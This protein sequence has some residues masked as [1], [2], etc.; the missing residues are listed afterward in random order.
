MKQP[1]LV[2]ILCLIGSSALVGASA[3]GQPFPASAVETARVTRM[4]MAPTM[5]APGTVVSRNDARIA[6]EVSGR[7]TWIAEPGARFKVGETIATIDDHAFRL[8]LAERE[9]EIGQLQA[10]LAY[11]NQQMA[12]MKR[13][14]EQQSAS[15]TQL[16]EIVADQKV[17]SLQ[18]ASARASRDR[19]LYDLDRS[20]VSAPFPG[21]WVERR[22]QKGEYTTVGSALGRL[23]DIRNLEV[24]VRAPM[25]VAPF[26]TEGGLLR[27]RETE[28][29][30]EYPVRAIIVVGD[31]VSRRL[32]IRVELTDHELLVGTAVR[33]A[34]P[35]AHPELVLAV[36]RDA[37]V[38]RQDFT[39]VF[40]V[41]EGSA[42]QIPVVV[43]NAEADFIAVKGNLDVNDEV[44]IRGA[45]RL[46][47]GQPVKVLTQRIMTSPAS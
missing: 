36:P 23:V 35:T 21:Q 13:L 32:E 1:T 37:L 15:R 27:L 17:T 22:Q 42:E 26:V 43:G 7:I 24:R 14:E 29:L 12:R 10:R 19:V 2:A 39:Y 25:T 31:E 5:L 18:L 46:R 3:L 4:E 8:I 11:D 9:A 47:D 20:T 16:D 33:V 6:A 38:I 44:V 45:E 30:G 34:V 40:R 28:F 41:V